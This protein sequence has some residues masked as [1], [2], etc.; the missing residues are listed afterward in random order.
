MVGSPIPR[1]P[2]PVIISKPAVHPV[3]L[4]ATL[5]TGVMCSSHRAP[6]DRRRSA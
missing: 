1:A 3:H 2:N 5:F 4:R 6:S